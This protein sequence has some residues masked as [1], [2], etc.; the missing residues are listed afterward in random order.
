[1]PFISIREFGCKNNTNIISAP[2]ETL[3]N[4]KT[5]PFM[6][7]YSMHENEYRNELVQTYLCLNNE[8]HQT[9]NSFGSYIH[10]VSDSRI[11]LIR[12]SQT[13]S[14]YSHFLSNCYS[15]SSWKKRTLV[16]LSTVSH[17]QW[18]EV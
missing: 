5:M 13:D 15:Q 6:T 8:E 9:Q 2:Q 3:W 12:C 11:K 7:P 10:S 4:H 1:M 18:V 17:D 14:H 16:S